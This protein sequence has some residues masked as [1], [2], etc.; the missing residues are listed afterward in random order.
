M[1]LG[2]L[3]FAEMPRIGGTGATVITGIG[4]LDLV[5]FAQV[6]FLC[7]H[8]PA[9]FALVKSG[10]GFRGHGHVL[11]FLSFFRRHFKRIQD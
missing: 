6:T 10:F 5:G 7:C 8:R 1:E 3:R 4:A 2:N 9:A 11:S